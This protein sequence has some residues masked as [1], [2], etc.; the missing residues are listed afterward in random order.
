[1]QSSR[2]DAREREGVL[3]T[4]REKTR[5]RRNPRRGAAVEVA[6][7][8]FAGVGLPRGAKP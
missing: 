1:M 8:Y 6:K 5:R 3:T 4:V 7:H 2:P